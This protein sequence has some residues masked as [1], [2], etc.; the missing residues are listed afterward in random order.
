M[1][2]TMFFSFTFFAINICSNLFTI[3][4][5]YMEMH[6]K[7]ARPKTSLGSIKSYSNVASGSSDEIIEAVDN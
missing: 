1:H 4:Y 5:K 2:G 7:C 6:G 3:V